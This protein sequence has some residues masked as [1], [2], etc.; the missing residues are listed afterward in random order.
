LNLLLLC[1]EQ[2]EIK[3]I[4]GCPADAILQERLAQLRGKI[5]DDPGAGERL[6]ALFSSPGPEVDLFLLLLRLKGLEVYF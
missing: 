4:S 2:K 3:A 5:K 1:Q 6:E